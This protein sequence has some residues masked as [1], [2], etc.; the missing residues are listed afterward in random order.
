MSQ[1][2]S[3]PDDDNWLLEDTDATKPDGRPRC[4]SPGKC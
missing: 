4:A 2:A 1:Q 3:L